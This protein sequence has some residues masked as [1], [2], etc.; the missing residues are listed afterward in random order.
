MSNNSKTK[1][2]IIGNG[3]SRKDFD[4]MNLKGKGTVFGC[5]ALYRLYQPD[6]ELPDY[7]VAIDDPI[8]REIEQ[9]DFPKDR[10]IDPPA[11]EK[12]EPVELHWGRAVDKS[13]D[14]RR[15]RSNAGFNAI[16]EAIKMGYKDIHLL[17]FDFLVVDRSQAVSNLFDGTDCYGPET[18]ATIDDTR[19][20][21]KYF[22][23]IVENNLDF[24]FILVFNN[25]TQIY[26]PET[27]NV[28]H[29]GYN[30]L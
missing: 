5:N 16:L 24:N 20:R 9:S 27:P 14:P 8:I 12:W 29:I 4:L 11:A 13:W 30:K 17:G 25:D 1:A 2:F 18:R 26:M 28:K 6:Y 3:S 19:N 23:W 15:P 21:F 10:F 7:L 22:G